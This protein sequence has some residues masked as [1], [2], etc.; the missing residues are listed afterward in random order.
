MPVLK[1]MDI[2]GDLRGLQIASQHFFPGPFVDGAVI[3]RFFGIPTTTAQPVMRMDFKLTVGITFDEGQLLGTQ[4]LPTLQEI[5]DAVIA[6][7]PLFE[8]D[9]P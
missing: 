5:R 2:T 8:P 1:E 3:A 4:Q 6:V 9:F 7:P